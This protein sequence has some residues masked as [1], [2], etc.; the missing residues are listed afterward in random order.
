MNQKTCKINSE[1]CQLCIERLISL[2]KAILNNSEIMNGIGTRNRYMPLGM[3]H[4][5]FDMSKSL[6]EQSSCFAEKQI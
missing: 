4:D 6:Y 3:A 2:Q 1:A 5:V